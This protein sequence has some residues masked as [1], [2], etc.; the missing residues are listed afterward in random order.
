MPR[1]T[2]LPIDEVKELDTLD[3]AAWLGIERKGKRFRCPTPGCD[4]GKTPHLSINVRRY[5]NGARCHKACGT[6]SNP[7]LVMATYGCDFSESVRLLAHQFGIDCGTVAPTR[8]DAAR[9]E[10]ERAKRIALA[11]QW[12]K[13]HPEELTEERWEHW[14]P[15]RLGA[16]Q[17]LWD[18]LELG[19]R[20]SG[21]LAS[22]GLDPE[23]CLAMGVRS[24]EDADVW[25][26]LMNEL[27]PELWIAMGLGKRTK[28]G[29]IRLCY[30]QAPMLLFGY[31]AGSAQS[32][33]DLR[34]LRFRPILEAEGGGAKY[35]SQRHK[36]NQP[37]LPFIHDAS[38]AA[39]AHDLSL[40]VCEGELNA[41]SVLQAGGLAL[42]AQGATS[43][44]PGWCSG[45]GD[46][47][48]TVLQDGDEAGLGFS[49][50]VINALAQ[51]TGVRHFRG[52]VQ[53]RSMGA[54]RDPNDWLKAG[55][56]RRL[57]L[58]IGA[59]REDRWDGRFD[60]TEQSA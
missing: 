33:E 14:L 10:R 22:R 15:H 32:L 13:D 56:L 43:W 39:R 1:S 41:L 34:A 42:S 29:T 48:V 7:D 4:S 28:R 35:L 23:M 24:V 60:A 44:H 3:V 52:R 6:M 58:E 2:K 17:F 47:R 18:H 31:F 26:A 11:E 38:E 54:G 46:L 45:W 49:K 57:L 25:R 30:A 27:D 55:Q 9:L 16:L 20:A 37:E 53:I 59:A 8:E 40:C 50:A 21:Y 51:H 5:G 19:P 12:R 36:V